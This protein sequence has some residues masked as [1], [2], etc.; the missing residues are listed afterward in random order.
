M[1]NES[2]AVSPASPSLPAARVYAMAVL[3]LAVGLGVGYVF[4]GAQVSES[5]A[6]PAAGVSSPHAP[7]M[8]AGHVITLEQLKQMADK[9]AAPLLEKLKSNPNNTALLL[10]V[11]ALYHAS[12]QYE[13]AAAYYGKVVQLDPKNVPARTKLAASLYRGGNPDGAID[14]LNQALN[15]E[16]ND[17][18]SLFNLGMIKFEGKQDS[19]G[20]LAAW[21]KL[22]KTNPQLSP[23]RKAEVQKL[24]AHVQ[25]GQGDAHPAQGA[26]KHDTH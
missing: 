8:A 2:I 4:R 22:L 18:N 19:K 20:A 1:A 17:A 9:Q 13:Q 5:A 24:M 11:G 10:Q 16:P 3:C 21:Q 23:E 15:V 25:N 7:G 12:H 26:G 14:Q 6:N